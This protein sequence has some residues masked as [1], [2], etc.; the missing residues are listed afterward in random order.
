MF[1]SQRLP[2]TAAYYASL[3]EGLD[4]FPDCQVVK[5]A[6]EILLVPETELG[7]CKWELVRVPVLELEL[8][9]RIEKGL[10]ETVC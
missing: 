3:P 2:Q 5:D 4:S 6:F 7:G 9:W 10:T 1:D 8:D